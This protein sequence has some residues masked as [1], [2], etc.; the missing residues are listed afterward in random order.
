MQIQP[1]QA[2]PP[3]RKEP[4]APKPP[5]SRAWGMSRRNRLILIVAGTVAGVLLLALLA[6]NLLISADWARDRVANRIREQTGRELTVNGTTALLFAPGPRIVITDAAFVDPEARAGT[7]DVSV[8]RLVIDLSLI[9]LLSR[10]V[11][12]ERIV[13]ERPVVTVRLGDDAKKAGPKPKQP[14]AENPNPK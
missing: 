11:D 9:E 2:Q 12:S 14:K 8:G 5:A 10:N 3:A 6:V 1:T 7:T 13:L 4:G